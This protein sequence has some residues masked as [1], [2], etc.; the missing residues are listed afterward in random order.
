[1]SREITGIAI[2]IVT[3]I[4]AFI[5]VYT[6]AIGVLILSY[7]MSREIF[8]T[9]GI[10]Y[11]H[12][13]IPIIA[14]ATW[15]N[16][17]LGILLSFLYCFSY[18]YIRWDMDVFLKVFFTSMYTGVLPVY[19]IF[20][21]EIGFNELLALIVTV[22]AVDISAYYVGKTLG[23]TPLAPK[24]SPKKTIEGLIGGLISAV[25]IFPLISDMDIIQSMLSGLI[26]GISAVIGDLLKSFIKRQAGIK[27]FS[28]IFGE[29]GGFVDR[30]DSLVFTGALY[31]CIL[32]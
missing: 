25:I 23:K 28:N 1:M 18:G 21:R 29:H 17:A 15:I 19:L 4:L 5:S 10:R 13:F 20:I 22:W 30:F 31:Y 26:I 3:L 8:I 24:L 14:I 32:L 7:F 2:G 11:A 6:V 16:P 27:D 9:F 12:L